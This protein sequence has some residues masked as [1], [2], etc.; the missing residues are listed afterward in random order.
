[1]EQNL[2]NIRVIGLLMNA[3]LFGQEKANIEVFRVLKELGATVCVGINRK[4]IGSPVESLLLSLDLESFPVSFGFQWSKKFFKQNPLLMLKNLRYA[5]RSSLELHHKIKKFQPTHIHI[6]NPLAYSMVAPCLTFHNTNVIYRMGDIAPVDSKPNLWIWRNF[7]KR[8][9][10][11]V[12]IS[13][14][15]RNSLESAC[16]TAI[17]KNKLILNVAPLQ[18]FSTIRFAE[19]LPDSPLRFTFIGQIAPHK[20]IVDLIEVAIR[21]VRQNPAVFFD[22]IGGSRFTTDLEYS[23]RS[24][25][26]SDNL[27]SN[28]I[29]H[30]YQNNCAEFLR[31]STALV[32]PSLCE[33][34]AG[35]V[36]LEAKAVGVPSLVYPSGGLPEMITD[37]KTGWVCKSCTQEALH[38]KIQMIIDARCEWEEIKECCLIESEQKFGMNRFASEWQDV[39]S[40]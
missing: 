20:G 21:I 1:M 4:A 36:V 27:S 23:L 19:K 15:V 28:I 33:E 13:S 26:A 6:G 37:S 16:P 24:R 22:I 11:V 30:G 14:Y 8:S 29:F 40:K 2:S 17:G 39:Y 7:V 5:Y 25:V 38:E 9:K 31:Y 18:S 35:N 3:E 32:V 12:V 10:A 34:A